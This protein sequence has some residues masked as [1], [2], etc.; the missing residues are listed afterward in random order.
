MEIID[1]SMEIS[2]DMIYYPGNPQPEIEKYR[3]IPEDSTTESK[4]CIGSHTG[5]HVDAP[6]HIQEDGE[7]VEELDLENFYGDAQILDLTDCKE[8]VDREELENAEITEDIVL[9]KTDNSLQG[10]EEFREDFTYLTLE[11]VEYLIEQGVKTVGIDYLSL[12]E[13]DGGEKATEAHETANQEMTVIEGLNLSGAESGKYT[14]SG[15]PLKMHTDG[16]P[17]RAA[18][19]KE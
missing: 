5:T 2:E 9:L 4:I 11:G 3:Q 6:Q 7:T 16:A 13:F 17:M 19:I 8:K 10:Y 1:V 15:M 12:V 14:F 18:L